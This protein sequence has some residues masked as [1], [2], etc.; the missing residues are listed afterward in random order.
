MK[1]VLD[2]FF[3]E[4]D[5]DGRNWTVNIRRYLLLKTL[6]SLGFCGTLFPWFLGNPTHGSVSVSFVAPFSSTIIFWSSLRLPEMFSHSV[7][8]P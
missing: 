4:T 3:L 1:N 5:V 6:C 7:Y 2:H 8:S